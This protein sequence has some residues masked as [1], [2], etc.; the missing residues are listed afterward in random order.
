MI[1]LIFI[2]LIAC[3]Q[4]VAYARVGDETA[5]QSISRPHPVVSDPLHWANTVSLVLALLIIVLIIIRFICARLRIYMPSENTQRLIYL[6]LIPAFILPVASFATFEGSTKVEFCSSCHSAMGIYV[7][8]MKNKDSKTL[9]AAHYRNRFIQ[10]GQCYTCH[11]GYKVVDIGKA[12]GKGLVHL[13]YWLTNSPTGRGDK[14]IKLYDKGGYKNSLCLG[15]H[16]GSAAF[17]EAGEGVHQRAAAYLVEGENTGALK[18]SCLKCHGPAHRSLIE[19]HT[20]DIFSGKGLASGRPGINVYTG[21]KPGSNANKDRPYEG[22]P[23]AIPHEI[24][25]YI[26]NKAAN[27]CLNECHINGLELVPTSHLANARNDGS[28]QNILDSSRYNCLQCHAPA[29]EAAPI[30]GQVN[31]SEAVSSFTRYTYKP[32]ALEKKVYQGVA[33]CE[34]CHS[35]TKFGDQYGKWKKTNHAWAYTDLSTERGYEIARQMGVNEKPQTSGKCL[36]CHSTGYNSGIEKDAMFRIEDGVQCEQCHGAGNN[37][38]HL[39]TMKRIFQGEI[40]PESAGQIRPNKETCMECH[41]Q[42]HSHILPFIEE[43]RFKKIFH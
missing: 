35:I 27:T 14:Q 1:K 24:K 8:D 34:L 19:S 22:A 42:K 10:H 20:P 33:V 13:Y 36:V 29:T 26:I 4:T 11:A 43:E 5:I 37:Y 9:A 28:I 41:E 2:L 21:G 40:L 25:G 18:M 31:H 32:I 38:I 15:C 30:I 39:N 7:D 23:P 17:L 16:S 6:L 3:F 12:K